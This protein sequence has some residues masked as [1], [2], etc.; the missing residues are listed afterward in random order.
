MLRSNLLPKCWTINLLPPF[1]LY[2]LNYCAIN[3]GPSPAGP[4]TDIQVEI[5]DSLCQVS[6]IKAQAPVPLRSVLLATQELFSN[7]MP[8]HQS[9]SPL[10][11]IFQE[12]AF[13]PL[14]RMLNLPPML[15]K[16]ASYPVPLILE[17]NVHSHSLPTLDLGGIGKECPLPFPSQSSP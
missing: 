9:M 10:P 7:L 2:L 1:L 17:R 15:E 12:I 14:L 16:S 8:Q 11:I 6:N 4:Q 13:A 3:I 5:P